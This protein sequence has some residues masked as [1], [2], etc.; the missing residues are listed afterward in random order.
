MTEFSGYDEGVPC[1]IDLMTPDIARAAE[2][3][4]A[5]FGWEYI[6]T[7]EQGGHYHLAT[8]RGKQVAG[9]GP[10]MAGPDVP[11]VW[12]TYMWANDTDAVLGRVT[13]AD[14]KVLAGPMDVMDQGRMAVAAD[15]TG[16]AFGIW[17]PRQHRG[18][19]LAN[20][21]GTF[22]WNEYLGDDPDTARAFYEKV[23]GY[24]YEALPEW[25]HYAM[26]KINGETRGGIGPKP[27]GVPE[28]VPNFWNVYFAVADADACVATARSSGGTVMME[29]IDTSA[30]RMAALADPAGASFSVITP[31]QAG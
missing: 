23:F 17:E 26:F 15:S 12:T 1:W 13:A 6:D 16:A 21:P 22:T 14:G 11:P 19:Q 10:M 20:E 3:Y 18:A 2:F 31:A 5:L 24:T 7:G 28:G 30:G 8:L 9:I 27:E 4:T 25:Q 29:P